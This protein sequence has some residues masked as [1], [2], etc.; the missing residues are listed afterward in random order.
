M[1]TGNQITSPMRKKLLLLVLNQI[2]TPAIA[3]LQGLFFY[4]PYS[5]LLGEVGGFCLVLMGFF[6]F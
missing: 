1:K 6:F 3:G 4:Q 2:V 5:Y